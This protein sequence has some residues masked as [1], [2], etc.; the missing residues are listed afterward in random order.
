VSARFGILL[1]ALLAA[2][3]AQEGPPLSAETIVVTRPLPGSGMSAGYLTLNNRSA[4][5]IVVTRVASP[6][7]AS[8]AMH[9]TVLEDGVSRMRPL[10]SLVVPARGAVRLEPG[11]KHLMLHGTDATT[12]TVTLHFYAG[13]T[14]L[15]TVSTALKD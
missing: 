1:A 15:L 8:V 14:P 4:E 7:F 13:D 10:A 3:C 12:S 6:E 11:G 5:D 9:E 2:A